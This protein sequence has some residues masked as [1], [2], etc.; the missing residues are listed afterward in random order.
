VVASRRV[1]AALLGRAAPLSRVAPRHPHSR[2]SWLSGR[3]CRGLCP[4]CHLRFWTRPPAK[5]LR[6]RR[7]LVPHARALARF[8]RSH[9]AYQSTRFLRSHFGFHRKRKRQSLTLLLH[10]DTSTLAHITAPESRLPYT[11]LYLCLA[12]FSSK[13]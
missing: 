2:D 8:A 3:R 6:L 13:V 5:P 1:A 11:V 12:P 9:L 4:C 10:S 7:R